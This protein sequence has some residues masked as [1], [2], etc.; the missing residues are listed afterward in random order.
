MSLTNR[1]VAMAWLCLALVGCGGSTDALSRHFHTSLPPS[2]QIV[3]FTGE[4]F[5]DPW[6]VW[7]I[8]PVDGVFVQTLVAN[9]GLQ[10]APADMDR[11]DPTLR[12]LPWWPT[13]QLPAMNE[14]YFRDPGP[15]D[16]SIYRVWVD[17]ERQRVFILFLNT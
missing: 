3:N 14:M 11:G 15:T 10:P 1:I 5:K 2:A 9:A 4:A 16:G 7:E 13:Q 6:F 12:N 17:Q 8:A